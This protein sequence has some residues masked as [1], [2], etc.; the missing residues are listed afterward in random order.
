M[1]DIPDDIYYDLVDDAR[2]ESCSRC[3]YGG[4]DMCDWCEWCDSRL[5]RLVE[6]WKNGN[7]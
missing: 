3:A 5:E 6:E 2:R 4:A 7:R 1:N